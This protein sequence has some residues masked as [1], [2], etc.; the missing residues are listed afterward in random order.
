VEDG[1]R[2]VTFSYDEDALGGIFQ[3]SPSLNLKI[4]SIPLQV[5]C[6]GAR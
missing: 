6:V 1:H 4:A 5:R 2:A 3:K